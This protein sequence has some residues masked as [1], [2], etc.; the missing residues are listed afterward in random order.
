MTPDL[1][2]DF[3]VRFRHRL[4]FTDDA[5]DESSRTLANVLESSEGRVARV[6]FWVDEQ[7]ANSNPD[8]KQRIQSYCSRHSKEF[9][10]VGNVQTLPGGEAVKNDVHIVERMLRCFIMLTLIGAAMSS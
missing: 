2:I 7:V 10:L 5:F 1:D 3:E 6:Q 9:E 4:R 8:L